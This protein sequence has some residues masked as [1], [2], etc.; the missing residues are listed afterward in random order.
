MASW[1]FSLSS[2]S[3]VTNSLFIANK[4]SE[5]LLGSDG[6]SPSDVLDSGPSTTL[7]KGSELGDSVENT[8]LTL[9]EKDRIN[10]P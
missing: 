7:V 1:Y 9:K 5:W 4:R 8:P 10:L 3:C 2:F 6:L